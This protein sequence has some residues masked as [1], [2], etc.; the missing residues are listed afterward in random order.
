LKDVRV[1]ASEASRCRGRELLSVATRQM[2]M[3][4]AELRIGN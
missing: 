1:R 2:I 3:D 4:L